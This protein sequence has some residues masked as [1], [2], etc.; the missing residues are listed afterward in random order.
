MAEPNFLNRTLWIR[1]NL[2][3]LRRHQ[4]SCCAHPATAPKADGS[5]WP[6]CDS[7]CSNACRGSSALETEHWVGNRRSRSY[8]NRG[9]GCVLL[10]GAVV[11]RRNPECV[12]R[13]LRFTGGPVSD[14]RHYDN[15]TP[16]PLSLLLGEPLP[17]LFRG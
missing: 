3:V 14:N 5:R 15:L 13:R 17:W 8:R 1:D 11:L 16:T 7:A 2:P 6:N 12:L 10:A 9:G 4:R